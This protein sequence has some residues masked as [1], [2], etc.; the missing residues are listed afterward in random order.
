[1]RGTD[2]N[3][4]VVP[5][6]IADVLN[7]RQFKNFDEFRESFWKAVSADSNLASQFG[8]AN[9]RRMSEGLAPIARQSQHLGKQ[10]SYVLHH[11]TPIQHGGPVYDLNNIVVV[12]PRLHKEILDGSFHFGRN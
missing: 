3:F 7:G 6:Q 11:K 8:K 12:T 2:G 9:L 5:G 1:L 4:G 10:Q